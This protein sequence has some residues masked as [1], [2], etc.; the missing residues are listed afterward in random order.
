MPPSNPLELRVG[1]IGF[2]TVGSAF[3]RVL[4]ERSADLA[5]RYGL[6]LALDQVAVARPDVA[7]SGAGA[8]RVHGDP[9]RLAADPDLDI[10]V[11]ATGALAAAAWLRS[12]H[13]RGATVV[14]ANK[15]ALVG[16]PLL[17]EAL[18]R[19]DPRLLCEAAA[20][21]AVPVVR[22]LR[23]S[24]AADRV[25]ELRGVLNGTTTFVL[26]RLAEGGSLAAAV[27]EAQRKGYAEADPSYDLEGR[28]AAA[29]LA[30]LSTLAWGEPIGLDRIAIR[31][32]EEDVEH[33]VR[34]ARQGGRRVRLVARA[35][36]IPAP[37]AGSTTGASTPT[38]LEATVAAETLE[39]TDPLAATDGVENVVEVEAALAGRLLWRGAGA[40]GRATASALLA[41]TL[42]AARA[43]A[44]ERSARPEEAVR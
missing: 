14:T 6:R 41:D 15:Q 25:R 24:L 16:D 18:A 30:I 17:L 7:R 33:T 32:L 34:A 26:S 11:E 13:G 29:K 31:G 10:V 27:A 40:G 44:A 2:G 19:H 42:A 5:R 9:S 43:I 1:L 23:E 35:R 3:A 20:G 4:A 8:A 22:A 36:E 38:A 39:A 12:A 28:D 21:G 37:A